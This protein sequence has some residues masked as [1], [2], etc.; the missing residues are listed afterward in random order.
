[1][2]I[3]RYVRWQSEICTWIYPNSMKRFLEVRDE[4]DNANEKQTRR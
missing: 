4:F 2:Y 1:M 3:G